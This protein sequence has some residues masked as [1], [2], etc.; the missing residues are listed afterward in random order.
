MAAL[1]R[2]ACLGLP[3]TALVALSTLARADG[4]AGA[5]GVLA[6]EGAGAAVSPASRRLLLKGFRAYNL[7]E[8]V[9]D[10]TFARDERRGLRI[11]LVANGRSVLKRSRETGA[12]VDGHDLVGRFNFFRTKSFSDRVGS[13]TDL[14]FLGELKQP[15]PKGFRGSTAVGKTTMDMKVKP[16]RYIIPVVYPSP[17]RCSP[18]NPKPCVP[19]AQ[20]LAHRK[21]EEGIIRK[22]YGRYGIKGERLQI[23]PVEMEML[24]QQKYHMTSQWP[25]TGMLAIVYCLEVFPES[26][27]SIMGFDFGSG[28]LGHYWEPVNKRRTV[29]SMGMEGNFVQNLIRLGRVKFL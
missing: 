11:A 27:V 2:R 14:W 19:N 17:K 10:I 13:R 1:R 7:S 15:G 4:V 28:Q 21:R 6:A 23:M 5:G 16:Q 25:S 8:P 20:Q 26:T 18:V 24:L 29:H 22:Q 9:S 3:L 12:V